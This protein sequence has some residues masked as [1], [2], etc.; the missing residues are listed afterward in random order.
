MS[1]Q[2]GDHLAMHL[3]EAKA[4]DK[5]KRDDEPLAKTPLSRGEIFIAG[6][7]SLNT[8]FRERRGKNTRSLHSGKQDGRNRGAIIS[9]NKTRVQTRSPAASVPAGAAG[10]RDAEALR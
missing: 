6:N 7:T 1:R 10:Q 5:T 3:S 8:S 2:D 4:E 9:L